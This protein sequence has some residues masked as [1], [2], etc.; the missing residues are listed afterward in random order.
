LG[1]TDPLGQCLPISK[2]AFFVCGYVFLWSIF[3]MVEVIP[4]DEMTKE[5]I[6]GYPGRMAGE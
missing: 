4:M 2:I 3:F 5:L 1:K 6:I